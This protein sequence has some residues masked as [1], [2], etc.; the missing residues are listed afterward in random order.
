MLKGLP[1][2]NTSLL[3]TLEIT[4]LKTYIRL[5]LLFSP[6]KIGFR[7]EKTYFA[8]V[9][10]DEKSLITLMAEGSLLDGVRTIL[11]KR[12][13]SHPVGNAADQKK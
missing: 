6:A 10:D 13:G 7:S 2:T 8:E 3:I 12:V 11:Q 5:T 9:N 4:A 1:W